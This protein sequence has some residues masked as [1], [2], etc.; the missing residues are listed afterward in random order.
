MMSKYSKLKWS[1][2]SWANSF[3]AKCEATITSFPWS[4]LLLT[5]VLD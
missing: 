3:T 2:E 4:V 1:H 5:I